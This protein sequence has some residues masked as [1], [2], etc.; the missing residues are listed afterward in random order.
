ML[1]SFLFTMKQQR[2]ER[3]VES[4]HRKRQRRNNELEE[5]STSHG[6]PALFFFERM[7][8]MK[9][10]QPYEIKSPKNHLISVISNDYRVQGKLSAYT[11]SKGV[12]FPLDS[13]AEI[14]PAVSRYLKTCVN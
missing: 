3:R 4:E 14:I 9:L 12:V 8:F 1:K 13:W 6:P 2:V 7:K 5:P 11:D 10:A